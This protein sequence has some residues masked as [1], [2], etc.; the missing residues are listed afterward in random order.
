M[1][2]AAESPRVPPR[3]HSRLRLG[4]FRAFEA[5]AA[6]CGGRALYRRFAL[7]PGRFVTREETVFVEDLPAALD[8]FTIAQLSDLHGGS[9][10]ARGDLAHVIASV[11]ARDVDLVVFTGD[12]VTHAWHEALPLVEDLARAQGRFGAYA[13]FGN[14]DYKGR[15]ESRIAEALGAVGVRFLRNECVR[16]DV[17]GATLALSGIEDLEEGRVVDVSAARATLRAGDV[18]VLLCHNPTGAPALARAGCA[19]ILSGHTHGTQI[20]APWLRTLGPK[21][22]GLRVELGSTTLIVSRGLGVVGVPLRWRSSPEVVVV[23]LRARPRG[24]SGGGSGA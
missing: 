3:R 7:A 12:F 9:F 5:A 22:P 13:V 14:H 20:D 11:S 21:H 24:V 2:D 18:E 19:L 16:L 4:T 6:W 15:A 23:T 1:S 8:G 10:L 17:R